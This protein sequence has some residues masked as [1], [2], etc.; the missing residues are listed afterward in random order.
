MRIAIASGKGGTGKT[1]VAVSLALSLAG[2]D[3]T[4]RSPLGRPLLVDCDVEAPDAHLFLQPIMERTGKASLLVPVVDSDRCT[5]CGQCADVC[6]FNALAVLGKGVLVLPELCHGCGSCSLVCPEDAIGETPRV[7]GRLEGGNAGAVRF[8]RGVLNVGEAMPVP[9]IRQLKAWTVPEPGQI[10]IVDAPP[11][12]SCPV[13][14]A[15]RDSDYVLLVTEPTPF[16]LHDLE[17]AVD[18]VSELGLPAGIVI[19]RD[20]IGDGELEA[21]CQARKLPILLRIPFERAI[22]EGIARGHTL[23]DVRPE[24]GDMLRGLANRICGTAPVPEV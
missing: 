1:T 23:L 2:G 20:G 12:T 19:N 16:G 21:F 15:I 8:A 17:C 4:G 13:V 14:E 11:G 5:A 6:A 22:A 10:T 7:I 24:Y 3:P 9:V 18:V